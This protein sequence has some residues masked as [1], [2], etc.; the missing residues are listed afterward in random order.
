MNC[1]RCHIDGLP[2]LANGLGA[3]VNGLLVLADDVGG[4]RQVAAA[5]ADDQQKRPDHRKRQ[6][7]RI[8]CGFSA[9]HRIL[10]PASL[11]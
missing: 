8:R 7:D 11:P 5:A 6:A 1:Q 4:L 3:A 2:V 10:L 9:G